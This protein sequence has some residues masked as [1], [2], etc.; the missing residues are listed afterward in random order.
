[1]TQRESMPDLARFIMQASPSTHFAS[2]ARF[3]TTLA[4]MGLNRM[5]A[6]S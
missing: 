3:R 4:T 5:R 2:L 6:A 1:M